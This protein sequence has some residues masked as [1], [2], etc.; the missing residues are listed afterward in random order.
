MLPDVAAA[1]V[2]VAKPQFMVGS[3]WA[4]LAARPPGPTANG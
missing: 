2:V 1:A 3:P 4:E